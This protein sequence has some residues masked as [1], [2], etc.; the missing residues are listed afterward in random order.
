MVGISP[1]EACTGSLGGYMRSVILACS[2]LLLPVVALGQVSE[3][4][5]S[6]YCRY[7]CGPFIPLLTTPIMSLT[8]VSP[9]PVGAT[10]ATGGLLAGA[11]NSTLAE[12]NGNTDAVYTEPMW[13]SGGG[14]PLISP[15]VNS[16]VGGM[17]MLR[18][19][20]R[21]QI[22]QTP[23][24][25]AQPW[26]F[27]SSAEGDLERAS[28]AKGVHPAKRAYTNQDVDQLNQ[29]NGTVHYDNRTEKIQ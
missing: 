9:N 17:R 5:I 28:A 21:E 23:T 4:G 1:I 22:A 25:P 12:P 24:A 6:D 11:R 19:E 8:T 29:Q 16:P 3:R 18:Q 7:G 14:I 27:F 20:G 13:R 15:A 2:L 26:V 10:N